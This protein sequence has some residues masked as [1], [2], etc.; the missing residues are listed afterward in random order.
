MVGLNG[1]TANTTVAGC[2]LIRKK[3]A[4]AYGLMTNEPL[5]AKHQLVKLDQLVF[6]GWDFANRDAARVAD[7]QGVIPPALLNKVTGDLKKLKPMPGVTTAH[8]VD[9]FRRQ[10]HAH[11]TN[12]LGKK[13]E[14]LIANIERFKKTHR[15]DKTVVVFTGSPLKQFKPGSLHQN[16]KSFKQALARNHADITSGMLYALAAIETGSPFIDFTTNTTLEVKALV[17]YAKS[18]KVPLAGKDGKTG[19]TMIKTAL[20]QLLK[21]KNLKLTGWYSTNLLGNPDGQILSL[22]EYGQNKFKDK[23]GVL[24]PILKYSDFDHSVDIKYYGPRGDNKEAWDNIDFLGWLG[25]PMTMKINWL[26]RDSILAAPLIIDLV[27]LM[28]NAQRKG[29]GGLQTH[30]AFFFKNPLGAKPQ[31]LFKEYQILEKLYA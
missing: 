11:K 18:K 15:L 27:R 13:L 10:K 22:P 16:I 1:A 24:Q 25:Q 9:L 7:Q 8:D 6:G 26:G 3:L 17:D 5:F 21:I 4:P 19:Q 23:L 14:L 31:G 28:E 29:R 30:L 20:A 2:Y 12:S